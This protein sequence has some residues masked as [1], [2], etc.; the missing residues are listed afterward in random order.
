MRNDKPK[1]SADAFERATRKQRSEEKI[2]LRLYIASMNGKARRAIENIKRIC[3]EQ[4][5]NRCLLEIIDIR[6]K[7]VL[8]KGEQ[9]VAVP[10]LVKK[11][12][13]PLRTLIG[14]LADTERVLLGLDV[15][16]IRQ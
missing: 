9:I 1:N 12:P 7:P 15:K 10:T 5:K 4:L 6:K 13:S 14:D 2:V 11:V 16:T 8:A 3:D